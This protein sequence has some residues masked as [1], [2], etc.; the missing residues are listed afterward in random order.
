MPKLNLVNKV[1]TLS[2]IIFF[3]A[4][5]ILIPL[6]FEAEAAS[7]TGSQGTGFKATANSNGQIIIWDSGCKKITNNSALPYFIPT[8]TQIEWN[9]FSSHLPANVTIGECVSPCSA[10]YYGDGVTCTIA[11]LGSYANNLIASPCDAGRYGNTTGNS[12]SQCNGACQAGYYCPAG[13]WYATSNICPAGTWSAAGAGSCT[14]C[15]ANTYNPSQ[16][17]TSISACQACPYGQIAVPGSSSCSSA[18]CSSG[19]SNGYNYGQINWGSFQSGITKAVANGACSATATCTAGSISIGSEFVSSCAAGYFDRNS[20]CSDGCESRCGDGVCNNGETSGTCGMDCGCTPGATQTAYCASTSACGI[21][22]YS[23]ESQTCQAN[24][25]FSP[26]NCSLSSQPVIT[27]R[28]GYAALTSSCG[29]YGYNTGTQVCQANG[30]YSTSTYPLNVAPTLTADRTMYLAANVACGSTCTPQTQSCGASGWSGSYTNGTCTVAT[31]QCAGGT[32]NGYSYGAINYG[33]SFTPVTKGGAY[34]TCNATATCN[35]GTVSIGSE[36]ATC[37]AGHWDANGNCSDGCESTCGDGVCNNGETTSTCPGDC[38]CSPVGSTRTAY[39]SGSNSCGTYC[40]SETQTCQANGTYTGTYNLG[41]CTASTRTGYTASTVNCSSSCATQSQ[42]CTAGGWSGSGAG[43]CN[44][45]TCSGGT[46]YCVSGTCSVC[47]PGQTRTMY[48]VTSPSCGTACAS[49]TQT[50]QANGTWNGSYTSTSCTASTRTGYTSTSAPCNGSCTTQSQT[51]QPNGSWSGSGAASCS[52]LTCSGGTPYCNASGSCAAC[53]PGQT[54]TRYESGSVSC[55]TTC[56]SETQTCQSNG[57]WN[58]SYSSASCSPTERYRYGAYTSSCGNYGCYAEIQSCQ[59]NGSFDGSL[60]GTDCT[61]TVSSRTR[62][63][64]YSV[65]CGSSCTSESQNC[66]SNGTWNGAYTYTSCSVETCQCSSGSNSGY[67]YG[68][69]NYG[70]T[71]NVTKSVTNGTCAAEAYCNSGTVSITSQHITQ[72]SAGWYDKNNSCSDGCESKCGDGVCNNGET[73]ASCGV[74]CG[75][76]TPGAQRIM[77]RT[78]T[79]ACG[80]SCSSET[81]TCQ[82]GTYAWTGTFT[83]SSDCGALTSTR[84]VYDAQTLPCGSDCSAGS[85]RSTQDCHSDGSWLGASNSSYPY[86]SCTVLNCG[87][88]AGKYNYPTCSNCPA[89]S[90]CVGGASNPQPT[91]C[92]A[93]TYSAAGA[94]SC[95]NCAAD[96]YSATAGA[97]SCTAC[98]ANMS[99]SAGLT[100]CSPDGGMTGSWP[101]WGYSQ[102]YDCDGNFSNGAEVH[103]NCYYGDGLVIGCPASFAAVCGYCG[104]GTCADFTQGGPESKSNC[105]DCGTCGD[106]TCGSYEDYYS[107]YADCGGPSCSDSSECYGYGGS[108]FCDYIGFGSGWC[109]GGWGQCNNCTTQNPCY[110]PDNE[111]DCARFGVWEV[112]SIGHCSCS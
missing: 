36:S 104:D 78:S 84:Y 54:R 32:T 74:D 17:G 60:T 69:I 8:K 18:F 47:S 48:N 83:E 64:S 71:S 13:T 50:C 39:S 42:T 108:S 14:L 3:S 106:G 100:T 1:I 80:T 6:I 90:Y 43:S 12:T 66:Q 107:C 25:L 87:C 53:S 46:P 40:S 88:A 58:G 26:S 21:Y 75:C 95:T 28:A 62:Y 85:H 91:Q 72:C 59:T 112:R 45:T 44:V 10:G 97:S 61:G 76:G 70:S 98:P 67:S 38:G 22:A 105:R 89:G 33:S 29:T 86:T 55:G 2:K 63:Q 109:D 9:Y 93:G 110:S 37:T 27:T 81:Q 101:N 102:Y 34:A 68:V 4:I 94:S 23:S 52:P 73:Q 30:T 103:R 77:Y 35:N 41:S 49:E 99:S 24:F 96:T 82:S 65:A 5:F 51:C 31:C 20:T 56:Y 16:G 92:S 111:Y 11:P 57:S 79:V 7:Y 19:T 15:G